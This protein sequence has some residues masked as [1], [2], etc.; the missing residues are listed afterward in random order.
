MALIHNDHSIGIDSFIEFSFAVHGANHGYINNTRESILVSMQDADHTVSSFLTPC[1]RFIKRRFL[2][3][4]Q[5]LIQ[6]FHP[7]FQQIFTLK[8]NER[9]HFFL[10]YKITAHH[11]FT[12][13][14]SRA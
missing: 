5:K 14:G 1:F 4:G 6:F 13:C 2:I 8:Q 12:K 7:L 9:I 3:Y 11:R 10:R